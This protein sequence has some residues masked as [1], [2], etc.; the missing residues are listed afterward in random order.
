MSKFLVRL[1]QTIKAKLLKGNLFNY[2]LGP[3]LRWYLLKC[4]GKEQTCMFFQL[5]FFFFLNTQSACMP[6]CLF[7]SYLTSFLV[8]FQKW[9]VG[10]KRPGKHFLN[11]MVSSYQQFQ[12][13]SSALSNLTSKDYFSTLEIDG[14]KF[15]IENNDL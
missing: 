2:L 5:S 12:F 7:P 6:V 9:V 11:L 15:L 13:I 10:V 1:I 8:F 3:F 4:S 14:K